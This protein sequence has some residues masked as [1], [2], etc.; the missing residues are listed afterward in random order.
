MLQEDSAAQLKK[1]NASVGA[2]VVSDFQRNKMDRKRCLLW[3]LA[4]S[5]KRKE[6]YS[7][8]E[9]NLCEWESNPGGVEQVFQILSGLCTKIW[10]R[11]PQSKYQHGTGKAS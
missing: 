1:I 4:I 10:D 3:S 5:K 9:V 7:A 2:E 11:K 8:S 6:K